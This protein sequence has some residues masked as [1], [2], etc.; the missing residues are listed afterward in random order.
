[1][2]LCHY[3]GIEHPNRLTLTAEELNDWLEHFA[4]AGGEPAPTWKEYEHRKAQSADLIRRRDE[5][6][7]KE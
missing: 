7:S 6:E 2:Q 4:D 1:M 5:M 3:L